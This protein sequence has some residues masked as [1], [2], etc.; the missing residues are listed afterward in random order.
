MGL[1]LRHQTTIHLAGL[2]RNRRGDCLI[3][4][5]TQRSRAVDNGRGEQTTSED[6]VQPIEG[7]QPTAPVLKADRNLW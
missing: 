1:V 3:S 2:S 5:T 6:E 4:A 7:C